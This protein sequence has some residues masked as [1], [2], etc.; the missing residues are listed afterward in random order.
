MKN[1]GYHFEAEVIPTQELIDNIDNING[2]S[3][4]FVCKDEEWRNTNGK[5][6]RKINSFKS[7][8]E[9][10]ILYGQC[11]PCYLATRVVV[12]EN[13]SE[14]SQNEIKAM[15]YTVNKLR[16]QQMKERLKELKKGTVDRFV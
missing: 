2:L 10:S 9:I 1:S 3:F 7:M 14:L 8:E 6:L 4:Q 15:K 5:H 13:K 11:K 12:G 16:Y